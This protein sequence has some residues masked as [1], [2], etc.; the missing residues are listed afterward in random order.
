MCHSPS[1]HHAP[2][3]VSPTP[4]EC[5]SQPVWP[6][7]R[8]CQSWTTCALR[9]SKGTERASE[10]KYHHQGKELS[11]YSHK[12]GSVTNSTCVLN[13]LYPPFLFS[14]SKMEMCVMPSWLFTPIYDD[15]PGA[16]PSWS[17]SCYLPR[18]KLSEK[19]MH[20]PW[21]LCTWMLLD[22]RLD[23]STPWMSA[24]WGG[25]EC[26]CFSLQFQL[27]ATAGTNSG[28]LSCFQSPM[29][30]P[31]G[32]FADKLMHVLFRQSYKSP[33]ER[34]FH[35]KLACSWQPVS[36]TQCNG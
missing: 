31:M 10:V 21:C 17:N 35:N 16:F 18:C 5:C 15:P 29:H 3:H 2:H 8:E 27:G 25:K 30:F 34:S 7:Q 23:L 14:W 28:L 11:F 9:S 19:Q 4:C 6:S 26:Q 1:I 24:H 32:A 12:F 36:G 20:H 33:S 22:P 13:T